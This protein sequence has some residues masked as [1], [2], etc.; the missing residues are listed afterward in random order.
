MRKVTGQVVQD[1][2]YSCGGCVA[3]SEDAQHQPVQDLLV[4]LLWPVIFAMNLVN[5]LA[6][7]FVFVQSKDPRHLWNPAIPSERWPDYV[8]TNFSL[9]VGGKLSALPLHQMD[10]LT[11]ITF[12]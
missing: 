8:F 2:S 11:L 6:A 12:R 7:L 9:F 1:C 3:A 10:L 4:V 5:I